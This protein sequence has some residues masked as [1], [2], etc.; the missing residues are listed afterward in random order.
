MLHVETGWCS[1]KNY[2][3]ASSSAFIAL[4]SLHFTTGNNDA[5]SS[6]PLQGNTAET[7]RKDILSIY[8]DKSRPL[9]SP[10][11]EFTL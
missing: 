3:F 5:A 9:A 1:Q 6:L 10:N 4:Q 11:N 2:K 7:K 8:F